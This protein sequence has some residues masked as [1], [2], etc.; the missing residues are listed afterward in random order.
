MILTP[1]QG[2]GKGT[3]EQS[4]I[5]KPNMGNAHLNLPILLL[6]LIALAAAS[7]YLDY[8]NQS[9][10]MGFLIGTNNISFAFF[11]ELIC[12]PICGWI[13][14]EAVG[15]FCNNRKVAI[16]IGAVVPV[17]IL[18]IMAGEALLGWGNALW[19]ML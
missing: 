8:L 19:A 7:F 2:K 11:T 5:S 4:S 14:Y 16:S 3:R 9:Q 15:W 12:V 13:I 6:L 17:I 18:C 1:G 10:S